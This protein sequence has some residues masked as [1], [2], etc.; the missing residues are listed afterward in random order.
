MVRKGPG[1]PLETMERATEW[2]WEQALTASPFAA[3]LC[4]II[5]VLLW[6]RLEKEWKSRDLM[7]EAHSK[8]ATASAA[9][10]EKGTMTVGLA[11]E[12]LRQTHNE[13][14]E[15]TRAIDDLRRDVLGYRGNSKGS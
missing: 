10:I 5:A 8:V 12:E 14:R 9:A 4:L 15:Q 1:G 13:I 7:W 11:V 6:R 3:V 2:I